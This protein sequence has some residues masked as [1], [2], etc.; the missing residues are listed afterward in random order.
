MNYYTI[1]LAGPEAGSRDIPG[2][3]DAPAVGDRAAVLHML[4]SDHP[5]WCDVSRCA[6]L[7]P[8]G[9]VTHRS[10]A[11]VLRDTEYDVTAEI[12]YYADVDDVTG[13]WLSLD[14]RDKLPH[15]G[16][17]ARFDL[18]LTISGARSLCTQLG[19]LLARLPAAG[20]S[21]HA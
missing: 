3:G 8:H 19:A 13:A 11:V 5:E 10:T 15:S 20:V 4:A 21:S 2:P 9:Y 7:G 16:D 6:A 1:A 12:T 17:P 18:Q 14:I